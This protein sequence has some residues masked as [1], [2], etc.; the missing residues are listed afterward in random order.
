[1]P[2]EAST[3]PPS[4]LARRQ[5]YASNCAN[6]L[7]ERSGSIAEDKLIIER[8]GTR[9]N[10]KVCGSVLRS[11][12]VMGERYHSRGLASNRPAPEGAA[13]L[14]GNGLVETGCSLPST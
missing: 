9:R 6:L 2:F 8:P 1:M 10:A 14:Q 12:E 13:Q 11:A 4:R 5:R 3:G 7:S